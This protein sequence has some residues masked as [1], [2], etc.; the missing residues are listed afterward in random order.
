MN[1][2]GLMGKDCSFQSWVFDSSINSA[3]VVAFFDQLAESIYRPMAVV[4]DNA[5]IHTS[6]EFTENIEKWAN[7]GLVIV[8]IPPYSPELNLI[9]ILWRKIK[10]EWMPFSAYQSFQNLQECLF[11]ILANIG[12]SYTI[13]FA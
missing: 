2:L 13:E 9:E 8:K 12:K 1:V 5:S 3:V 10:Y 7:K 6:A 4:I 11:E